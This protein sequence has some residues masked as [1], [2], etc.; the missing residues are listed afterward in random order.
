MI[1]E[2]VWPMCYTLSATVWGHLVLILY[3]KNPFKCDIFL[4]DR[5]E[6]SYFH[7]LSGEFSGKTFRNFNYQKIIGLLKAPKITAIKSFQ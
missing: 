5:F 2:S 1:E 3:S 4:H 7:K 6:R